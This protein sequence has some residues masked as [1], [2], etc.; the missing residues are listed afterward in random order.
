MAGLAVRPGISVIPAEDG[1]IL[2]IMI[3]VHIV[4]VILIMAVKARCLDTGAAMFIVVIILVT[5]D[6]V[7]I[8]GGMINQGVIRYIVA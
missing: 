5:T 3:E 7:H 8:V 4:P 2:A 1:E 6:A